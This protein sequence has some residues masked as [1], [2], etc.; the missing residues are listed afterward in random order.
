MFLFY[1]FGIY[2]RLFCFNKIK[3]NINKVRK[4]NRL[5]GFLFLVVFLCFVFVFAAFGQN[6]TYDKTYLFAM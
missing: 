5:S 1:V 6:A 4:L 2:R 3:I